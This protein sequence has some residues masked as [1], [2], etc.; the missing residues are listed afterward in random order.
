MDVHG[1]LEAMMICTTEFLVL[2]TGM[3][4]ASGRQNPKPVRS[5]P[6]SITAY[7]LRKDNKN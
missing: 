7:M 4:Q 6:I 5:V 1:F 2:V 3:T